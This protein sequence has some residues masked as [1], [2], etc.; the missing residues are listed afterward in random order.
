MQTIK[1]FIPIMVI[2]NAQIDLATQQDNHKHG[3]SLSWCLN[4]THHLIL[5]VLQIIRLK[6]ICIYEM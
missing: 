5:A 6:Y 1:S 2:K 4:L 3:S